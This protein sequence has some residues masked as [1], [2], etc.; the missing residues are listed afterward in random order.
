[1]DH[2]IIEWSEQ[3]NANYDPTLK[4]IEETLTRALGEQHYIT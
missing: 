3:Y 4:E 2:D 1:M